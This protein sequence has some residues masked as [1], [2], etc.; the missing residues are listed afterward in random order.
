MIKKRCDPDSVIYDIFRCYSVKSQGVNDSPIFYS[1]ARHN[2]SL[3]RRGGSLPSL[4]NVDLAALLVTQ[5][6]ISLS[7]EL[8]A[9]K[10]SRIIYELSVGSTCVCSKGR[11]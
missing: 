8:M 7:L 1:V 11:S 5:Q 3:Q 10:S 9:S 6:N 2:L 4:A